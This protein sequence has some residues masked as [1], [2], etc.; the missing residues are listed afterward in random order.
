LS[1]RIFP[2]SFIALVFLIQC[3]NPPGPSDYL[4]DVPSL[5]SFE[6]TPDRIVFD[7]IAGAVDT[8]IEVQLS[9]ALRSGFLTSPPPFYSITDNSTG[10]IIQ[11]GVFSNFDTQNRVWSHIVEI[12]T[13]TTVIRDYTIYTWLHNEAGNSL[14]TVQ[15]KLYITGFSTSPPQ[16]ISVENPDSV[17]I[18]STGTIDFSFQAKVVHPDGQVNI[19]QVLVDLI[20][21]TGSPLTGSPF[22]LFDDGRQDESGD[23]IA[24][25]SVYTRGFSIGSSNQ[26]DNLLVRYFA[27][28]RFGASSDT[29]STGLAI[30]R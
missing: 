20:D 1:S 3:D 30:W 13:Q 6:I 11:E 4:S 15:G 9:A 2:V 8:T 16:I 23:I 21:N 18:P 22:E 25:D 12:E 10:E 26:P 28:D 19:S 17:Q 24:G 14:S 5:T 7:S 27:I 29:V